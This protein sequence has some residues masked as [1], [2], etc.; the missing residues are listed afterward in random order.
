MD[1]TI[2]VFLLTFFLTGCSGLYYSMM[3]EVGIPR[4][5]LVVKRVE[6]A[7]ESQTEAGTQ[8]QSALDRFRSV[9]T[10]HPGRLEEQYEALKAELRR[11]EE[12]AED[13]HDRISA[14]E[15]V[16]ESLFSE[17][18][19]ELDQYSSDRLRSMSE[20]ELKRTKERYQ[21]MLSAMKLAES[22]MEPVLQP[23][24]DNVLFLKHN[25]NARAVGRLDTEVDA[26]A[27]DVDKLIRE[28]EKA[29]S[30]ADEFIQDMRSLNPPDQSL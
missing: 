2:L 15:D 6:A 19:D 1:K 27:A 22:R 23:L 4:R 11:S 28:V 14:L 24:R 18:E 17:W 20:N 9:V 13:V 10:M 21:Q 29:V 7:R 16:S 26:V 3:E 25:L 12:K 8:L 5:D 30:E